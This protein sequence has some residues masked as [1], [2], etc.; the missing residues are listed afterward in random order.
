MIWC[1]LRMIRKK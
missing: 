1:K